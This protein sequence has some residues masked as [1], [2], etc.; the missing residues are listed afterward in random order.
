M[1]S[2][3][4]GQEV[5]DILLQVMENERDKLVVILAGYKDRMDSFFSSNPGMSS[6]IAH[7]LDFAAYAGRSAGQS[8]LTTD[9]RSRFRASAQPPLLPGLPRGRFACVTG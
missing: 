7:H 5:I 2:R 8:R 4:H 1:I 6:R 3:D 9:Q